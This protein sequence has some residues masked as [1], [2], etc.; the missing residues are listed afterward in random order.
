MSQQVVLRLSRL[1]K[2]V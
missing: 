2:L 1:V